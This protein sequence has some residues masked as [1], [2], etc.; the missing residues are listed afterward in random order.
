VVEP[1]GRGTAPAIALGASH[2]HR[3]NPEAVMAV[4][5]ADHH[6]GDAPRFLRALLAA[7]QVAEAGHLVTL[8]ITPT[9]ASTGY[10]YIRRGQRLRTLDGF[11]IYRA[12][13]FT[14]KPNPTMAQAFVGS[15][16]YSWNSGMFVWKV[17][18]IRQEFERQM[19][20]L[21][22]HLAEIER[23]WGTAD[24]QATL[25]RVWAGVGKHTIDY[26]IMEHARDVAVIPVR[27][28]WNDVGS[29]Q[30]L[31][32]L[33]EADERGNAL[34]G[35]HV[36]LDT[37]DTLIYSPKKLVAA[38]GLNELIVIETDDALLICPRDR[39]QEVRDIVDALSEK[40][41]SDLL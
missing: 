39:S 3:R 6:I 22:A 28:G 17:K 20:D 23:S 8:G 35:D 30:T 40:G 11:D 15:R 18:A 9:F 12:L 7:A 5:T 27:I 13:R 1:A 41:R 19:P 14:E 36:T 33:L 16:M 10:G 2:I 31:M 32:E 37:R 21:S 4:V 34:V 24:E 38:I 26:G 29:W 25:Q